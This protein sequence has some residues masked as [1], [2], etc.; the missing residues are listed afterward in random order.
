MWR[1]GIEHRCMGCHST[2][3]SR[4]WHHRYTLGKQDPQWICRPQYF[5]LSKMEINAWR[6]TPCRPNERL[7]DVLLHLYHKGY[8]A[9]SLYVL[10]L[11]SHR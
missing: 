4:H 9:I 2:H 3:R 1:S 7:A 10:P 5:S 11:F 8:A 6:A